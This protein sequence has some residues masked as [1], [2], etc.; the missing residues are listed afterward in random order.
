[1]SEPA[2]EPAKNA[3]TQRPENSPFY[4]GP[5]DLHPLLE[6]RDPILYASL[7]G[8]TGLATALHSDLTL[9]LATGPVIT[10]A[11]PADP[12]NPAAHPPRSRDPLDIDLRREI[13]GTNQLPE[14]VTK[15]FWSFALDALRDQTLV[16]LC[17]AA[18]VELAFG[19]YE[20][21]YENPPEKRDSVGIVD[22][23]E[24]VLVIVVVASANDY[25]KQ[26]QFR[27]LNNYSNSIALAQVIR[28]GV[29]TE[30]PTAAVVVGDIV[31]LSA[32][33]V[34]PADGVLISGFNITT[35][36]S[37]LTGESVVVHKDTVRDPF[38]LGSTKVVDGVG[39]MLVIA[40]GVRSLSGRSMAA[41]EVELEETPLQRKLTTLADD[42]AKFGMAAAACML[43]ILL[44]CYFSV[45]SPS[46]RSSS[47]IAHDLIQIVISAITV[48]VIAIPEGLP[49]AVTLAL[50]YATVRMLK[51]NNLVRHLTACETMGNATTICSDKTG[52]LTLNQMTVVKG[53]IA[54]VP[55]VANE[56]PGP[57]L[58]SF[59]APATSPAPSP[60]DSEAH[61]KALI[62]FVALNLN[63]NSTANIAVSPETGE[64][65]YT[66]SKT[67]IALLQFAAAIG[68]PF[69]VDRGRMLVLE[70]E[71]FNSERKRMSTVVKADPALDPFRTA[72]KTG[73]DDVEGVKAWLFVKG[74]AEILLQSC[75]SFVGQDGQIH[76]MTESN[77]M[78]YANDVGAY[79]ADGLRTLCL[80][81]KPLVHHPSH[82][83][84]P[85]PSDDPSAQSPL[86][87]DTYG[88]ILLAVIGI[89]DPIRPEVPDA[90]RS[91]KNAGI[92]VRMVT[93]DNVGTARTIA[94]ECGILSEGGLVMEGPEF[95]KLSEAEMD[96]F[97]PRLQV[98]A[99]SSPLDKQVLVKA[100]KRLGE[101][102]AVTGDG[103]NDAPALRSAD[104]GFSMGIAGTEV[105]KEASDVVILDDNFAS[106]VKAV[107]WGR[108]VYDS[109]RKFL[110]FQLTVNV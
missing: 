90:V 3:R 28:D 47:D 80:A 46:D 32:G 34:L 4:L 25:R 108:S 53:S 45:E 89:Q 52:T 56:I 21:K 79:A 44:I 11:L 37:S 78:A 106:I 41:L 59:L 57:F 61:K 17:I 35:D 49:L 84:F 58:K 10:H 1:M 101:T 95:R 18:F 54:Q 38:L 43:V 23:Q 63:I 12:E 16:A 98:L 42:L 50:A 29:L 97:V 36:E 74:A 19:V 64:K 107:I 99:R 6:P 26:G 69:E 94:R 60:P 100:L 96:Q 86:L 72:V 7:G 15:S 92:V 93:G 82:P 87:E 91:C 109:V 14:P 27:A 31:I 105:A 2:H 22:A 5:E 73:S 40:T 66:G 65:R 20:Y 104:V 67:E 9:G 88:L 51:D 83:I 62:V 13:F 33:D 103:T 85:P 48:I 77:R 68:Y 102:V 110:Q 55:F 8:P 81:Y 30:I 75:S 70:V 39:R 71:P 24:P 76:P